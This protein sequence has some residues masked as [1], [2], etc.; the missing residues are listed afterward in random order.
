MGGNTNLSADLLEAEVIRR[1]TFSG[2]ALSSQQ[3]SML[4]N[5]EQLGKGIEFGGTTKTKSVFID[6]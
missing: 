4:A 6:P 2:M 5:A 3:V 1:Q